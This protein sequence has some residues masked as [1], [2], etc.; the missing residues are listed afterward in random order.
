MADVIGPNSYLPGQFI[1]TPPGTKCDEHEDRLA[2]KRR[3]GETDSMGSEV[4]DHCQ[5]CVD[6]IMANTTEV[7]YDVCEHCHTTEPSPDVLPVRDPD[8]GYSGRVYRLCKHHRA[9]LRQV[10]DDEDCRY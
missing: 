7:Q 1:K 6:R 9:I 2:V 4:S 5:E 10:H 8:E 3:V